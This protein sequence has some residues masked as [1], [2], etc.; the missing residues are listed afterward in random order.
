LTQWAAITGLP[1]SCRELRLRCRSG[2]ELR[3]LLFGDQ[4]AIEAELAKLP[5]LRERSSIHHTDVA[6]AM[7]DK[8]SQAIRRGRKTSS[9]WLAIAAG[10]K[11]RSPRCRVGRQHRCT[12]GDGQACA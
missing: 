3:F 8:P 5:D 11:G 12:Y 7:D 4:A 1:S 2:P 6:I 9:M 10:Q